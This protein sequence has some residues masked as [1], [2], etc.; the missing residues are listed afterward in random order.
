MT[1]DRIEADYLLETPGD[2][3]HAAEVI[4][5]EQSSG[6]FV[7]IPGETPELKER[8]AARVI[9]LE[10]L[11]DHVERRSLP[12]S[13]PVSAPER[14]TRAKLTLSWPL[15]TLGPSLPNLLATVAGN[16]FELKQV[17]GLK[18]LDIRLPDA[19]AQAYPGPRFGIAGTRRLA[20]V[21]SRPLIGTIIKPSVGLDPEG[22]ATLV[23]ELCDAGIDFI[24]DDELQGNGPHAPLAERV[25]AVMPCSSGTRTAP[26]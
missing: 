8:S 6:T 18:I 17:S 13:S 23:K 16:L 9:G 1:V 19:F 15:G 10:I 12:S 22:T 11:D 4:A 21:E 2:P 20:G 14:V 25:R 24:K 5:G 7:A 3:Q 26:V